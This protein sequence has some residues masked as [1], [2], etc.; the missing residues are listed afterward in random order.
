MQQAMQNM[1]SRNI[2]N[3]MQ[4]QASAMSSMNQA[5]MEMQAMLSNMQS[6]GSCSSP[7]GSNPGGQQG[8]G[9][10]FM[11]N[12]QQLAA[13]QQGI[14]QAMQ[15]MSNGGKLTQEQ[16]AQL[17]RIAKEQGNAQKSAEELAK[18]QKEYGGDKKTQGDLQKIAKD[19]QEVVTDMQSGRINPETIKRQ[20][21]ILSRLLDAT[22]SINDRDFEKKRESKPG[23]D[24]GKLSPKDLDPAT[25]EGKT[26]AFR[27]MLKSI[28]Q[29][30]TKDYETLIRQYFEGLQTGNPQ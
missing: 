29:G 22:R 8:M 19:M 18:E 16:Q 9:N 13:Q 6:T 7:G 28:Q 21:R 1:N 30:Y 12:V 26:R 24:Q 23:E 17:G 20:E 25:Q 5:A 10:S 15:Q 27:E 2:N 4:S 11:N 14:N 3:A